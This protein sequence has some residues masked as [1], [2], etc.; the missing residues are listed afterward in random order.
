MGYMQKKFS[1][2]PK[3]AYINVCKLSAVFTLI[4]YK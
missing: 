4:I 3:H 2:T 1:F